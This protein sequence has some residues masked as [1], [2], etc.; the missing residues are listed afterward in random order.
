VRYR[1]RSK[2]AGAEAAMVSRAL[3][4]RLPTD[5]RLSRTSFLQPELAIGFPDIVLVYKKSKTLDVCLPRR[6]FTLNHFRVLH[7]IHH[8]GKADIGTLGR[9][10]RI[11]A[12]EFDVLLSNLAAARLVLL[13]R[14]VV[15]RRSL[16]AIF[17]PSRII[18][19][20]AKL[21]D[22]RGALKQALSNQWFASHSFILIPENPQS[23]D[24]NE[25]REAAR[26]WRSCG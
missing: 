13:R 24:Y 14:N 15:Q 23:L 21:D 5:N 4:Y 2:Q 26:G 22:W 20:E 12:D 9:Q 8:L 11:P 18:A 3:K 6:H 10:L 19:I 7:A 1:S 17:A 25:V 16:N